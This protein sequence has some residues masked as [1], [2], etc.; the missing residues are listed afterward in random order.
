MFGFPACISKCLHR[1]ALVVRSRAGDNSIGPLH[2]SHCMCAVLS[3]CLAAKW[4]A[5][6]AQS[7]AFSP[8]LSNSGEHSGNTEHGDMEHTRVQFGHHQPRGWAKGWWLPSAAVPGNAH[9]VPAHYCC[10]T[11]SRQACGPL[12]CTCLAEQAELECHCKHDDWH[13]HLWLK[14]LRHLVWQGCI[15]TPSCKMVISLR[16]L[17]LLDACVASWHERNKI[18]GKQVFYEK[19]KIKYPS[20]RYQ[21]QVFYV[22]WMFLV[23]SNKPLPP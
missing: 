23:K 15:W 10:W 13:E 19:N 20:N 5:G 3:A 12:G 8:G 6:S 9:L 21:E 2:P 17:L 16:L 11:A 22:F 7:S 18:S 4:S 1:S 14:L